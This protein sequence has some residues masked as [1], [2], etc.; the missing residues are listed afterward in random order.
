MLRHWRD[1]HRHWEDWASM[2]VAAG[3]FF[4]PWYARFSDHHAATVN[5]VFVALA[6]LYFAQLALA[7]LEPWEEWVN[8]A[9]GLWLIVSPWGLS[10]ADRPEPTL[11]HL[12]FGGVI[13][14][15]AVTE[16]VEEFARHGGHNTDRHA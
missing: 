6:L 5:A 3:L 2:A 14:M 15:L 7:W 9:L 1:L 13:T 16:L 12:I 4:S 11:T 10:F 8:L